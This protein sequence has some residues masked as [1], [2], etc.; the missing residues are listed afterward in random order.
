[1]DMRPGRPSC[2]TNLADLFALSHRLSNCHTERA[3]MGIQR[4]D[5]AAVVNNDIF[6]IAIARRN[7]GIATLTVPGVPRQKPE[8]RKRAAGNI[9]SRMKCAAAEAGAEFNVR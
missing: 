6:S 5:T 4:L 7:G 2:R 8:S 3:H 9:N 1:M